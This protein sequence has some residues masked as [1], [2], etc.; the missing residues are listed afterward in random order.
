M[1]QDQILDNNAATN[2]WYNAAPSLIATNR[3]IMALNLWTADVG[4][5]PYNTDYAYSKKAQTQLIAT[6]EPGTLLLLGLGLMGIAG[7]RRKP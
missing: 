2:G 7:F 6:P 5:G 4:D 1:Y 3:T